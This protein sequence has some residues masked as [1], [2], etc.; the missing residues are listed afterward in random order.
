MRHLFLLVLTLPY[1][2]CICVETS[3]Q[4][5]GICQGKLLHTS[6]MENHTNHLVVMST[7]IQIATN[8]AYSFKWGTFPNLASL[9][10][11][12]F[13]PRC[14]NGKQVPICLD[15]CQSVF[16]YGSV[17]GAD[18]DF[19]YHLFGARRIPDCTKFPGNFDTK[20]LTSGGD[21]LK[22]SLLYKLLRR[23]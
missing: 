1:V 18:I 5:L 4:N 16:S 2:Y 8:Q 14:S 15:D 6:I 9:T 23:K 7:M 10:C 13:Y 19:C 12:L 21:S 3:T 20:S 22:P 11:A 17:Y